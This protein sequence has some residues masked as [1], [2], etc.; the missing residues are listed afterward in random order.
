[1]IGQDTGLL[2][3]HSL[4]RYIEKSFSLFRLTVVQV[5]KVIQRRESRFRD[6]CPA[7]PRHWRQ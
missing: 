2:V 1:M 5:Y 3:L 6:A 4:R 7:A